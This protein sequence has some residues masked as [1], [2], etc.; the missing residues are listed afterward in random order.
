LR[1][2][3]TPPVFLVARKLAPGALTFFYT[4][5]LFSAYLRSFQP[6]AFPHSPIIFVIDL[7]VYSEQG[8]Y[9]TGTTV[10]SS[11]EGAIDVEFARNSGNFRIMMLFHILQSFTKLQITLSRM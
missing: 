5:L 4:N 10:K 11:F 6:S 9:A 2:L 1:N 8:S 7:R 3:A